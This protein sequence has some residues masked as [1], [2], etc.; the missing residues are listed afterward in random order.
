MTVPQAACLHTALGIWYHLL[1]QGVS[2][3]TAAEQGIHVPEQSELLNAGK[4]ANW[5][6]DG[7][8]WMNASIME[9]HT[10]RAGTVAA[11]ASAGEIDQ[12]LHG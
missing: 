3:L 6:L 2:A 10:L 11:G 8:R 9:G 4:G 1:D 12:M 5:Q 7:V